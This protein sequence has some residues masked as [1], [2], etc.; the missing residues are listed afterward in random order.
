MTD[1]VSLTPAAAITAHFALA[2]HTLWL[3]Q[4]LREISHPELRAEF[5]LLLSENAAALIELRDVRASLHQGD[6]S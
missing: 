3:R 2:N 5:E 6:E 1:T 4:Q